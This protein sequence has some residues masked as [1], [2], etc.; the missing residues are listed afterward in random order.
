VTP[1]PVTQKQF[2]NV[3]N[4]ATMAQWIAPSKVKAERQAEKVNEM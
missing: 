2:N 1:L 3:H 4:A